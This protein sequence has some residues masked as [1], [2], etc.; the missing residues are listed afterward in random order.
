MFFVGLAPLRE[1]DAVRAMVAEAV[2]L[3]ADDDVVAWLRSR[4]V[5]LVLDNLEH[6]DAVETVVAELLVGEVVVLATSRA[7]LH[8]SAEREL[9]VEPLPEEAAV[10]LFVSRAAAAGRRVE[11]DATV[12][13]VCR[14]LDNL[15][16][17]LELAAARAKLLSPAAL[18]Q[19]LDAALPLLSGGARD[20]PERQQTLR[21]TIEWSHDLLDDDAQAAFRRLSVFRGSFTLDAAEAV[22]GADLDQVAG[23]LDQSLLKPLGEERIFL[24]ETIREYARERL[25]QAAE[26]REYSLRQARYYLARLEHDEPEL[27]GAR[28]SELIEW[29]KAEEDNLRAMLDRLASEEVAEA[30]HAAAL[31]HRYWLAHGAYAE[32]RERMRSS[33][34]ERP[35]ARRESGEASVLPRRPRVPRG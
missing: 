29:S 9:P 34:F 3:Q 16:L 20:L 1:T 2:G 30:A 14:R 13:E 25:D 17:A 7:P 10:E 26:T 8:L 27:W 12:A 33:S 32:G 23:L 19:R 11:A 18:L 4:R 35:P 6:L 21:A 15:P 22:A 5:L 24:L 28:R 31:L